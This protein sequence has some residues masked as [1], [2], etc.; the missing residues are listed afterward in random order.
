M[1]DI[2]KEMQE[3]IEKNLP[4]ATAGVMT[5]YIKEAEKTKD[6]LVESESQVKSLLKQL[7]EWK[8]KTEKLERLKSYWQNLNEREASLAKETESLRVRERDIKLEIANIRTAEANNR[9]IIIERLVEKVFGHP[10]VSV[11][12]YKNIPIMSDAATG[13]VPYQSGSATENE[14]TT[15]VESKQ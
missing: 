1:S 13:A 3:L 8:T 14:T 4:S 7:I 6:D 10:S 2:T 5:K 15:T 12:T 9:N 11:S